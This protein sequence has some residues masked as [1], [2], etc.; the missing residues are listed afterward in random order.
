MIAAIIKWSIQNRFFVLLGTAILVGFGLYS[1]KNTPIDAIPDLSD[2]QV[3][4]KTSYPGQAPQVVEDQVTYPLTTAMLSVPGA[5]TVR[6]FSFFGDSYV[7]VI[8]EDGTDLYWARSRVLEYLNQVSGS[9]PAS[10]KPQLGP[11]ATGVGWVY[12]YALVDKT[13]QHDLAELRSIQDWF[14]KYELQTVPGVSEVATIGGMV[15]QYQIEVDP[16][17]LRSYDIPLAH[18]GMAIKKANQETG[19]SVIEM[20]EAEYMITASGYITSIDDIKNVPL[21]LNEQGTPLTIG[22]VADVRLGPQMRRGIAELNGEGEVVG[23]VVVMRFGENARETIDGIKQKLVDLT[24]SLPNG[25]EIVTVY[26]RSRLINKAVTNLWS[27]LFEELIVV[28]VICVLF[29]FHFRSSI[30]AIISLPLGILVAFGVMYLQ[31][32]SANIMSLA[33]IAIAIGA[34]SWSSIKPMRR[35]EL[36]RRLV[37]MSSSTQTYLMK[38]CLFGLAA[39]M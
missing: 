12:L 33:G 30:V 28:A 37:S 26:D 3:I 14:L 25:V 23:G 9:L 4:I 13:G 7:Y 10:A 8:F 38:D 22:D 2:V 15:R 11:D 27:K 20:A 18:V 29:L 5:I 31:G 32:I 1:V 24:P 16:N 17:L 19:A 6:G 39:C 34:M 21:G 35:M 36:G